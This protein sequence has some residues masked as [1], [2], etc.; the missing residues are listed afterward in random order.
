MCSCVIVFNIFR[1][2]AGNGLR[3]CVFTKTFPLFF[4]IFHFPPFGHFLLLL[5]LFLVWLVSSFLAAAATMIGLFILVE[6][7]AA[8][9][10]CCHQ[11]GRRSAPKKKK[12]RFG[13]QSG[14]FFKLFKAG[15]LPKSHSRQLILSNGRFV[16]WRQLL[17]LY[18]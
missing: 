8:I 2:L 6:E 15:L 5:F 16:T 4:F 10:S 12:D 1:P 13:R 14:I 18:Q 11:I 7:E 9:S 3:F 17:Q